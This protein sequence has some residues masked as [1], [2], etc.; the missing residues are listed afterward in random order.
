MDSELIKLIISLIVGLI[1]LLTTLSKRG[2]KT[3]Q[4]T[5]TRIKDVSRRV[6][7]TATRRL[8]KSGSSRSAPKTLNPALRGVSGF[9]AGVYIELDKEPVAIGRD[10]RVC[11]LVF[12]ASAASVSK[13]HCILQYDAT[14]QLFS[15][16]DF[17]STNGTFLENGEQLE[18]GKTYYL[19]PGEHFFL[20]DE[21]NIFEVYLE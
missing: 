7:E 9:F 12:P 20:S 14:K 1:T 13:R 8:T 16:E 3:I 21:K 15:L 10:F 5:T 11:H 2:R 4:K 6:K 19:K 18:A 17:W